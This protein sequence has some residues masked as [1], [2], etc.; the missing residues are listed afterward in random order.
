VDES[1]H[2]GRVVIVT[3]AAS[4]IGE[5]TARRF[6]REGARVV[7]ADLSLDAARTV[8]TSIGDA[9]LATRCDVA[10]AAQV[11]ATVATTVERFGG[12]DVLI[13]NAAGGT[14]HGPTE[15]VDVDAWDEMFAINV[16][17]G[18]LFVRQVVPLM[19]ARGGGSLLF[20][21]SL[22]AKQGT[23][24]MSVYGA[25]KAAIV[26]LVKSMA[27]E[28]ASDGIRVNAVCP[29]AVLTPG[30]ARAPIDALEAM[31]PF[32][33]VGRPEEIA[34]VFSFLASDDASYVTGQAL[35]VDGGMGAGMGPPGPPSAR[36][37]PAD[38][39]G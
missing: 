31:I 5:A 26:N 25:T 4:G 15:L 21:A 30:L 10:D 13:S 19:R 12:V 9:A 3:G 8:A 37:V 14:A 20:T 17:G 35:D 11:E 28:L 38:H 24:G 16:R 7:I 6:A 39:T 33:R 34:S 22:G 23:A 27:I 2:E 29:G 18:F 36:R 1:R 32:R